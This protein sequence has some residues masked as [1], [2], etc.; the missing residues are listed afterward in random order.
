MTAV[1][2]LLGSSSHL[3]NGPTSA[4]SLVVFSAL[5]IFDPDARIEAAEAM[6]LLG[7]MIGAIQIAIAVF[8]LGDLTRYI[9]ESVI[10]GFMAGAAFLL[11]LGQVANLLGVKDKGTGQMNILHR[12][13][14]TLTQ[15][16]PYNP[17]AI[18][19]SLATIGLALLFRRAVRRW[20]LPQ[21]DMLVVL[22]LVGG[23][24]FLLGW[25]VPGAAG[26]TLVSVAGAAPASL[27]AF[28]IPDIK[29]SWVA[30]LSSSALAIGFLGLIEALA[31]AKSI[32]VHTRQPL[33]YNRQCLAEGVANLVGAFFR[34][35]PGSGSL[36]R[37]AI[38]FQSGAA[39]RFSGILTALAV[40]L[41]LLAFAP[42][43]QFIPKPALAALL[44]VT[45]ARL[46]D[47]P[48]L[49]Y[50][51]RASRYDAGLVIVTALTA[52]FVGVEYSVLTGVA[53]SILL[54]VPRVARLKSAE[55]V[56]SPERVVRGRLP[57]DPP[58]ESTILYDLEGELF[59]G[60]APDL[61]RH[62][63]ELKARALGQGARVLVLRL[64]RVR[65]PDAVC[66]ERIEHF[67]RETEAMGIV[68]L[69]AGLRPDV[70]TAIDNLGFRD[71]YPVD[72]LFPEDDDADSATLA[73]VR[74]AYSFL[75]PDT[76]CPHCRETLDG[77]SG[78]DGLYYLV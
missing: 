54:F 66:L 74:H 63:E 15:G 30:D 13:W 8:R 69:L 59:F 38:N 67:L 4:I 56:V 10:L 22:L 25:T 5:S 2:S 1:A 41:A 52:V 70:L 50:A 58:C 55:L 44:V 51:F 7:A 16:D 73:A 33:D 48:R 26:K 18:A 23:S 14:I 27:P 57:G 3:I 43:T 34:C 36:S 21:M 71:W 19:I 39:T 49:R 72:R 62:L 32:A 29:F 35:L 24:A 61:D 65:N 78:R 12:V 37:S 76:V 77:R 75:G 60:A 46:I 31:V 20:R 53:L 64:K 17:R 68:V 40:A 28:H 45:A 11:A 42:L 9:S 47:L 6:F